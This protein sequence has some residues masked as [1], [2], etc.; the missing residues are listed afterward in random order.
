MENLLKRLFGQSSTYAVG[1]ILTKG[2]GLLLLPLYTQYLSTDDYGVLAVASV[3]SGLLGTALTGGARGAALKFYYEYEGIDRRR[4]YGSLSTTLVFGSGV[5]FFL[6]DA[7]GESIFGVLFTQVPYHP[8]IRMALW[9]AYLTSVFVVTTKEMMKASER[10]LVFTGINVAVFAVSTAFTIWWVVFEG[11]GAEG[12]IRGKL[13]GAGIVG[14]ACGGYLLRYIRPAFDVSMIKRASLYSLPLVPHF[15]SHW[16]LS[17]ADRVLLERMVPLS[18]VGVYNVGYK[19]GA[20]MSFIA[21]SGNNAIIPLY[22]KLDIEDSENISQV[23][24]VFTYYLC[25][26]LIIGVCVS[27]FGE[28]LVIIATPREYHSAG[29]I[30]PLVVLG[31]SFMALYYSPTNTLTITSQ[32]SEVV[33]IATVVGAVANIILNVAAIPFI[34]IYGAAF[35]TAATYMLMSAGVYIITYRSSLPVPIEGRRIICIFC[36]A[37]VT[38]TA[39]WTMSPSGIMSGILAKAV[40]L[41]V[42]PVSLWVFGFY[43]NRE[44]EYIRSFASRINI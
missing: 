28:E 4:F 33:G 41:L 8:Y 26:V 24:R 20:A 42:F 16:V 31:Y 38:F 14:L 40:S 29:G 32:R 12:A 30:I 39:G 37:F 44:R 15:L 6:V 43:T 23:A 1:K 25:V 11:Q 17:A 9:T 34:G 18:E 21:V 22:G 13:V 7:F 10:A 19:I 2:A 3:V 5:L 36:A 27:L 35:T